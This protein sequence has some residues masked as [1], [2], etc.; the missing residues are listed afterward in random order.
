MSYMEVFREACESLGE[1]YFELVRSLLSPHL[2]EDPFARIFD[3][4]SAFLR[5]L[6]VALGSE[7]DNFLVALATT[8]KQ[9]GVDVNA[10][11][12]E[13]MLESGD[14]ARVRILFESISNV[15]PLEINYR[16][17][18]LKQLSELSVSRRRRVVMSSLLVG[19]IAFFLVYLISL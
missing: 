12:L 16:E 18:L 19:A 10:R 15:T 11:S 14:R 4:P 2:G 5:S 13:R 6:R 8:L 9:R 17:L 7:A 1:G 3:D